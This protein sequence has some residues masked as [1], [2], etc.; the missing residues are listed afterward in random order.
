M[1]TIGG[2]LFTPPPGGDI[3]TAL[4]ALDAVVVVQGPAGVRPVPLAAFFTGFMTNDLRPDELVTAVHVPV[5]PGEDAFIKLGRK[6]ANTPAVV[7]VAVRIVRDGAT[8][9]GARVALGAA[10]PHPLRAAAAE[11]IL[12]GSPLDAA[13]IAEAA[14]A[15]ARDCEPFT[16]AVASAWYRRRMVELVVQRA[17]SE[18]VAPGAG[19]EA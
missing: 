9:T 2:N 17:L 15:A 13:T 12:V 3:A 16:D 11:S 8:V 18:L 5:A 10:G 1:G 19:R 7:T 14:A 6:Q 4:L